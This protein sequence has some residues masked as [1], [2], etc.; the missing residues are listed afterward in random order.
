M[1]ILINILRYLLFS[2]SIFPIILIIYLIFPR[3]E[4]N[5]KLFETMKTT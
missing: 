2:F 5:L 1:L 3:T 4:I